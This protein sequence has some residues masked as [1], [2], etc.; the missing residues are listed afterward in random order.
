MSDYVLK[1]AKKTG[2]WDPRG[3]LLQHC[4]RSDKHLYASSRNESSEVKTL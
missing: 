4:R 1:P 2:V 3:S